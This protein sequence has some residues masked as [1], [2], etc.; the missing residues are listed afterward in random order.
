M[1]RAI[2]WL[3]LVA[4]LVALYIALDALSRGLGT[5]TALYGTVSV[6]CLLR[7]LRTQSQ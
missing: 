6:F 3:W 1:T 5:K 7:A 2:P 4:S